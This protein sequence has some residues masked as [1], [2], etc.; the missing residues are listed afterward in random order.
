MKSKTKLLGKIEFDTDKLIQ[1]L[2]VIS[3][4]PVFEEEYN[5][6]NSGTWINNSLWNDNGDYRNTQYKDNPN[7]AKLTELG[8]KLTI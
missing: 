7:S 4:F 5:E 3:Q 1:D 6:F 8:K 2:E